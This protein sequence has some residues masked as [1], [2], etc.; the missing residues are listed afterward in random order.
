[1]TAACQRLPGLAVGLVLR[2]YVRDYDTQAGTVARRRSP[3]GH[4]RAI[5]V[6]A[7]LTRTQAGIQ[8]TVTG[9]TVTVTA[10]SQAWTAGDSEPGL[11]AAARP[12]A[13]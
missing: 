1:V 7:A 6:M 10:R 12:A 13:P 5:R 4:R 8:V 2:H 11:A 3:V 9:V